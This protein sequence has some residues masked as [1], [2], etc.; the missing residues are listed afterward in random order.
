M[1][2][3]DA[4]GSEEPLPGPFLEA[5]PAACSSTQRATRR[6][7]PSARP[8]Q[9]EGCSVAPTS[10]SEPGLVV[11]DEPVLAGDELEVAVVVREP[12]ASKL[13]LL[14]KDHAE[15]GRPTSGRAAVDK[16]LVRPPPEKLWHRRATRLT[17]SR[18]AYRRGP[19]RVV[20]E[21]A[22]CVAI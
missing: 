7:R 13:S 4:S 18:L 21:G 19:C 17:I 5:P 2:R 16:G 14:P 11:P 9:R 6:L 15:A 8:E 12:A 3:T 22:A 1:E 10:E 20:L